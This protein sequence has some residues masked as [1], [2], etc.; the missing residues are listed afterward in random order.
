MALLNHQ[1]ITD[2]RIIIKEALRITKKNGLILFTLFLM[3]KLTANTIK[4]TKFK[5]EQCDIG[6][7]TSDIN[8]PCLN[9][10]FDEMIVRKTILQ[11]GG[12]I[13]EPIHYGQWRGLHSGL[14][15]HDVILIKKIS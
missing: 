15:G 2:A 5:F 14:T 6:W 8:R 13:V 11:N 12:N 10:A 7:W 1:T 4:S 9:S 3:N